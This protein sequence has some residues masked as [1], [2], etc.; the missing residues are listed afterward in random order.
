MPLAYALDDARL[1]SQVHSV[2]DYILTHQQADGW[3]GPEAA[4][5]RT[6]WGRYPLFLG[7]MQLADANATWEAEIVPRL[8][9][10]N[11]LMHEMMV[12][13]YSGYHHQNGDGISFGDFQWGQVRYQDMMISL[14][15]LYESHPNG[16]AQQQMLVDNM[17]FLNNGSIDWAAW[18][19][20]TAYL[21]QDLYTVPDSVTN[22]NYMYEH[23]VNVGQ[24]MS[25]GICSC[26]GLALTLAKDSRPLQWYVV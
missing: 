19:D 16:T 13:D 21:K 3:I 26:H 25:R 5:A 1:K 18:Y 10:F 12:A 15:W 14:M 17:N 2:A 4:G 7:M 6:F 8:Y 9:R 23:G 20:E 11:S 24:G 22:A